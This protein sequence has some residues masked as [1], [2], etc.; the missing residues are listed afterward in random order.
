MD[1][2]SSHYIDLLD[3]LVG[4]ENVSASIATIGRDIEDTAALQ[5]RWRNG[6]LGMMAVTMLTYPKTLKAQLHFLEKQAL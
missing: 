1:E 5:L 2:P 4:P 6:A 3:W